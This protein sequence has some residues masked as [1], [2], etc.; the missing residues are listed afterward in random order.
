MSVCQA[1][2]SKAELSVMGR[3]A[4]GGGSIAA[5]VADEAVINSV[6]MSLIGSFSQLSITAFPI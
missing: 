5:Q 4:L 2:V 1:R 6:S 3:L